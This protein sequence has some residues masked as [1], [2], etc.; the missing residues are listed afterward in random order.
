MYNAFTVASKQIGNE[1]DSSPDI[2]SSITTISCGDG[3]PETGTFDSGPVFSQGD[4]PYHLEAF[5][6]IFQQQHFDQSMFICISTK[7]SQF[8]KRIFYT[9]VE[10]IAAHSITLCNSVIASHLL[11]FINIE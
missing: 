6:D 5:K 10:V 8:F 2:N 7:K 3:F 11:E 1:M 4:H 9:L